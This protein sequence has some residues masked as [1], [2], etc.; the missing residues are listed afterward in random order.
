MGALHERVTLEFPLLLLQALAT[1]V[2]TEADKSPPVP[3]KGSKICPS[4]KH[5]TEVGWGEKESGEEGSGEGN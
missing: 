2:Q 3:D 1:Q 4:K 5:S